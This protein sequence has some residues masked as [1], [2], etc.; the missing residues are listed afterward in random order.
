MGRLPGERVNVIKFL[1]ID[2]TSDVTWS[3]NTSH[4]VKKAQQGLFL[5]RKLKK[6]LLS[7]QLLTNF[8]ETVIN[9][10]SVWV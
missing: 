5:H 9:A 1:A 4:P 8:Y 7:C 6:S 3:L 2:I 10:S